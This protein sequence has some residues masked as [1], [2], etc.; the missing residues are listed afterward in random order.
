[1]ALRGSPGRPPIGVPVD[2]RRT[3]S[4]EAT[5]MLLSVMSSRPTA[6]TGLLLAEPPLLASTVTRTVRLSASGSISVLM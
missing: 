2:V 3:T 6:V 1:M 5:P 4:T